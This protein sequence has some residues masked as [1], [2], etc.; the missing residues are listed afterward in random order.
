MPRLIAS[1]PEIF[2]LGSHRGLSCIEAAQ[3][4]SSMTELRER[5]ISLATYLLSSAI[6]G[7]PS[8][9]QNLNFELWTLPETMMMIRANVLTVGV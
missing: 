4:S 1:D 8:P 5:S 2:K 3:G 9:N 7:Y 6:H